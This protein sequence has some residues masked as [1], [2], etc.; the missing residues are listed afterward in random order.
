MITLDLNKQKNM[1]QK[2]AAYWRQLLTS[3]LIVEQ[4]IPVPRETSCTSSYT[5]VCSSK[6]VSD[7]ILQNRR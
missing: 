3:G 2:E 5:P 4:Q 1:S 6:S 7:G